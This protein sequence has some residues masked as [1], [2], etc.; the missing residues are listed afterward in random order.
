[1]AEEIAF[2]NGRICN[3]QGLVIL[4]LDRAIL[5]NVV[6]HLSTSTFMPDY[7]EIKETFCGRTF[8]THFIRLTQKSRPKKAWL[9]FNVG[10]LQIR[11]QQWP[12]YSYYTDQLMLVGIPS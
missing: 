9:Q 8:E 5:H 11:Q 1:V 12:F 4:T 6:H 10:S 7:I 3:F 2:E